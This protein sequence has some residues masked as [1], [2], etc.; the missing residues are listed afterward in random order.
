M[1]DIFELYYIAR[2]TLDD[3]LL[4]SGYAHE[5]CKEIIITEK[6]KLKKSVIKE[7]LLL[8]AFKTLNYESFWGLTRLFFYQA[9]LM[10]AVVFFVFYRFLPY[11]LR[12]I[13]GTV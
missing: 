9:P 1:E 4:M 8:K 3:L 13:K 7:M 5:Q 11:A 10:D 2:R 6:R 12:H